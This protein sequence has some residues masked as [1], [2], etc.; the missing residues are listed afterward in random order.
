MSGL[1]RGP[2]VLFIDCLCSY[3]RHVRKVARKFQPYV[4]GPIP[5]WEKSKRE[6]HG[7][8]YEKTLA[9]IGF[10]IAGALMAL[11]C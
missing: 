10:E 8:K 4:L 6:R 2:A 3:R 9:G 7:H 5:T 11:F 1:S